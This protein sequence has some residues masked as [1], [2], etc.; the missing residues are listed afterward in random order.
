[1]A[2][3]SQAISAGH[4]RHSLLLPPL[5]ALSTGLLQS[6]VLAAVSHQ[7]S[8]CCPLSLSTHHVFLCY[9]LLK[10]IHS[11]SKV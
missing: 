7:L 1:M 5:S 8:V 9:F 10:F 2:S 11:T 3:M 6:P 4:F